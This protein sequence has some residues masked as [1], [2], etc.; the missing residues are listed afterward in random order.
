MLLAAGMSGCD[1]GSAP[2]GAPVR[3]SPSAPAGC[4]GYGRS[5]D[6][7]AGGPLQRESHSLTF[8]MNHIPPGTWQDATVVSL[9]N[10]ADAP[11]LIESVELVP[12]P[13]ASPLRLAKALIAPP[14]VV[15]H[16]GRVHRA[17][18]WPAAAGYCLAPT[19]SDAAPVLALRI[20][21]S[22]P[23]AVDGRDFSRN[24]AVDVHYR[25]ASGQRYVAA[26]PVRFEYPNRPGPRATTAQR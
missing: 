17:A 26:F 10:A 2:A 6:E 12:D 20:A 5:A 16:V 4:H 15:Q 23:P 25:T 3:S 9:D 24:N 7:E 18:R 21:P 1:A 8:G 11:V 19:G 22:R 13:Q 14:G